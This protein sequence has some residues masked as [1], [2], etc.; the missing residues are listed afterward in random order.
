MAKNHQNVYTS[1]KILC[2]I[3]FL[4]LNFEPTRDIIQILKSKL[5]GLKFQILR[6]NGNGVT[7][8]FLRRVISHVYVMLYQEYK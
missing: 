6:N 8:L 2:F 7:I 4:T 5:K 1:P 3:S